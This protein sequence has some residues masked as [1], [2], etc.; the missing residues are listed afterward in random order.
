M[1]EENYALSVRSVT[2]H[3]R[4]L[5]PTIICMEEEDHIKIQLHF[6]NLML[7]TE[8]LASSQIYFTVQYFFFVCLFKFYI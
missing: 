5:A 6:I 3:S 8:F 4:F 1:K 2:A 7:S